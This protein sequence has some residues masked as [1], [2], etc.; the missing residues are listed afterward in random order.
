MNILVVDDEKYMLKNIKAMLL[1]Y[2]LPISQVF[3]AVSADEARVLLQQQKIDIILCDIEMPHESGLEFLLWV[4][5]N[6]AQI[7]NLVLTCYADFNYIQRAMRLNVLD[8]LVKPISEM[9]LQSAVSKA[10]NK[11]TEV[12]ALRTASD[13]G[14]YWIEHEEKLWESF[15]AELLHGHFEMNE[16]TLIKETAGR[17]LTLDL[18][19]KYIP[20]LI[21][22]YIKWGSELQ[23]NT[24]NKMT[25]KTIVNNGLSE[26]FPGSVVVEFGQ[27]KLFCVVSFDSQEKHNII[28]SQ[29]KDVCEKLT[30]LADTYLSCKM[31]CY[32][33]NLCNAEQMPESHDKLKKYADND[34]IKKNHVM[35][36]EEDD[37]EERIALI[38]PDMNI[39]AMLLSE[40]A[41]GRAKQ[42]TLDLLQL[43]KASISYLHTFYQSFIQILGIVL[44]NYDITY[45]MLFKNDIEIATP[46]FNSLQN[47]KEWALL[48]IDKLAECRGETTIVTEVKRFIDNHLDG[49]LT[50]E[51]LAKRVFLHPDYLNRIFKQEVG[52]SIHDYITGRR[53]ESAKEMLS[54]TDL[55]ASTIAMNI[56]YKNFSQ[57]SEQFRLNVGKSPREYRN[58]YKKIQQ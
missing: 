46:D 34:V 13:Y 37:R 17:N 8:Y 47:I 40:G 57:F 25:M 49:K 12:V 54:K 43:D 10:I 14:R 44:K 11:L 22:Y 55:K 1:C 9:E 7:I 38:L 3:I 58:Y 53:I 20:L 33:G 30:A 51:L 21:Q 24:K 35:L 18:S 29:V 31:Y 42:E 32:I 28:F 41:Y 6:Y 4:N 50:R 45:E 5:E 23:K 56:G 39:L 19:T 16:S 27:E 2:N 52:V 48:V 26:A 15:W 36:L